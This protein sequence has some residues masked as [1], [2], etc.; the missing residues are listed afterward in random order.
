MIG[1]V[2]HWIGKSELQQSRLG[3]TKKVVG[4]AHLLYREMQYGT[5]PQRQYYCK[6]A[7]GKGEKR[8][9]VYDLESFATLQTLW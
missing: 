6:F 2:L 8:R 7:C 4:N 9:E 1:P 3:G 5:V